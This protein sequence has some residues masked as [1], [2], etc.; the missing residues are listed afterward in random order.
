ML[1]FGSDYYRAHFDVMFPLPA[2]LL[3]LF[4]YSCRKILF[5]SFM[6]LLSREVVT[7]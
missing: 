1:A 4:R 2:K 5:F 6:K 7:G 3:P